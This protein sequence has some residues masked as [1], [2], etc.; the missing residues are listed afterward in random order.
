MPTITG[1]FGPAY[2]YT[3]KE[4]VRVID[5]DTFIAY[6]NLG[7]DIVHAHTFRMANINCPELNPKAPLKNWTEETIKNWTE[8]PGYKAKLAFE[9][10]VGLA[11]YVTLKSIKDNDDKYGRY[12]ALVYVS[13]D[14]QT[15]TCVND[16]M[17]ESGYAVPMKG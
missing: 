17:I 11:K 13:D 9:Q 8:T 16:W 6:I 5:G 1:D 15:W 14:A 4:L 7:F 3:L 10:M 12:L 2:R